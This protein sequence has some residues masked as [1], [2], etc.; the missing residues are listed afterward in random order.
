MDFFQQIKES[1]GVNKIVEPVNQLNKLVKTLDSLRSLL[2]D[3]R[4]SQ[5]VKEQ[6]RVL[7][8][9]IKTRPN[10]SSINHYINHFLLQLDTENQL[11]VL[12]ELLEVYQDRWKNID[13]KTAET[14]FNQLK[15]DN[16]PIVL[17]HHNDQS[18]IALLELINV[19]QKTI[20]IVQTKGGSNNTGKEQAKKIISK[21]HEVKFID[22]TLLG[23]MMPNI[24][25]VLLGAEIVMH[26]GF[27]TKSGGHSI[28][29]IAN[30]YKRPVYVMADTRKILNKK[31]FPLKVVETLIGETSGSTSRVWKNAPKNAHINNLTREEV[32]N[33]LVEQFFLEN[34]TF[35]PDELKAQ[36]DK[37]TVARFI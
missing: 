13:R 17:F 25:Y 27:I 14:T 24:D 11:P 21:D 5:T 15:F 34:G 22:D 32:P 31:Y 2:T 29:A 1:L 10:I 3:N 18:L 12:K 4:V 19:N 9:L 30:F 8:S 20:K 36:I 35:T 7:M 37:I 16:E 33:Y 26:N 28:A 6:I 23:H